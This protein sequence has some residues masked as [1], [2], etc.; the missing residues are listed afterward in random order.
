[1]RKNLIILSTLPLLFIGCT[2][3]I[4]E[5]T[6]KL[7]QPKYAKQLEDKEIEVINNK[8]SLF[9]QGFD[10]LFSDIK[11]MKV[12]DIVIVMIDESANSSSA[13][14]KAV[15]RNSALNLGGGLMNP[16]EYQNGTKIT[17][18][19]KSSLAQ[20]SENT[21]LSNLAKKINGVTGMGFNSESGSNFSG[22][23]SETIDE[24]FNTTIASRIVRVLENGNY[25]IEGGREI[26][27]NGEKQTVKIAGV[28]R[29]YDIDRD[30]TINS[31]YISD[32]KIFYTTDGDLKNVT[33]RGWAGKTLD[34]I[35][36]F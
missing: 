13:R 27:V 26:M 7:E 11:A 12:N 22:T 16:V 5:P 35:W 23:G 19:G 6:L 31:R 15:E 36:P 18:D 21:A 32:A 10:P 33:E 24:A 14:N 25:Y 30:N 8:G 34:A 17:G 20:A 29:P 9:G 4:A 28:I 3:K 2:P 1:M